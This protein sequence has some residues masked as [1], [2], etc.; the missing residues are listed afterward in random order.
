MEYQQI[1][2]E[3]KTRF[4]FY[5]IRYVNNDWIWDNP[6]TKVV[7]FVMQNETEFQLV[8]PVEFLIRNWK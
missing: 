4:E 8:P 2:H 1:S 7:N 3:T 6:I 5:P